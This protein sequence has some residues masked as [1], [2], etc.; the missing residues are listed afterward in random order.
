MIGRIDKHGRSGQVI[1]RFAQ[2]DVKLWLGFDLI[3]RLLD[4]S[5]KRSSETEAT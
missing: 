1:V 5:K 4:M 2:R 3:E